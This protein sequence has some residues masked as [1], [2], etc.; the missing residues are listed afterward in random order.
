MKRDHGWIKTLL[1]EAENERMHLL[2]AL[3]LKNPGKL[4]RFAVLLS[5]GIFYNYFFVSYLISPRY[6]HRM[7]GYLEEEAVKTYTKCLEEFD[8]GNLDVWKKTE[9]PVLAKNYW[10]L[11]DDATMHDVIKNI[12]ADEANHRDVNHTLA[13]LDVDDVNP[14]SLTL[15]E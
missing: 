14:F 2:T 11:G 13:G 7:V 1:E 15:K 12:R 9:A 4:F 6:C 5:Q 10:K 8:K 3:Q